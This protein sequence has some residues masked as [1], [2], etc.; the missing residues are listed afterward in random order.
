MPNHQLV[1]QEG[2]QQH[3]AGNLDQAEQL[4]QQVI[5]SHPQD[6]MH[7]FLLESFNLIEDNSNHQFCPTAKH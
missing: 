6:A 4:Y 3:Q 2:W 5:D 7:G 1:L